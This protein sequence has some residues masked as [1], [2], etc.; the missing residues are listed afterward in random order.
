VQLCHDRQSQRDQRHKEEEEE[1][2]EEKYFVYG[3]CN[4]PKIMFAFT[5]LL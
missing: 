5:F 3:C 4:Y 2:E 1:E